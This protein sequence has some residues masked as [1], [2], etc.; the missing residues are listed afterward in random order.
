MKNLFLIVFIFLSLKTFAD[1]VDNGDKQFYGRI[2]FISNEKIILKESCTGNNKEFKWSEYIT[3]K[4]TEQCNHPGWDVSTSPITADEQC[5]KRKV[6]EFWLKIKNDKCYADEFS[7][8]NG[9]L[10]IVYSRGRGTKDIPVTNLY[11][12]IDWVGYRTYCDKDIPNNF[13][14]L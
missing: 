4:F 6:F 5:A 8:S 12:V 14:T 11:K 10:H 2:I 13:V 3:I 9:V 1:Y 7:I